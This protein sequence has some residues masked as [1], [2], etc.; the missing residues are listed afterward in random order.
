MASS[1]SLASRPE[2]RQN[3]T[4]F[5]I[6]PMTDIPDQPGM[7]TAHDTVAAIVPTDSTPMGDGLDHVL[8]AATSYFSTDAL[9]V[10]ADRRW[11]ILMSDGAH[12]AG[13]HN[14]LEFIAPPV[15]TASAGAS[16]ADKNVELFAVAYGI[17]GYS[18]VNHVA[19]EAAGR[20]VHWPHGQIR[21]VDEIDPTT[22]QPTTASGLA[23]ALRK[24]ITSG[25]T[26]ATAVAGSERGV[27]DR[28]GRGAARGDPHP[29]TTPGRPSC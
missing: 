8:A 13:T 3:S 4:T 1:A 11:L 5:D 25:L 17:V 12:N 29:S 7:K 22:G 28:P 10:N 19:D 14:P 21:N 20:L 23:A 26:S 6:V 15:G 2:T 18:N 24:A 9:S 16:L 27:R